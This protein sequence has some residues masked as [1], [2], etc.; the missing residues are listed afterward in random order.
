MHTAP[1]NRP[2]AIEPAPAAVRWGLGAA[3]L[4]SLAAGL[5]CAAPLL[6]LVF[7]ISAAALSGLNGLSWLQAPMAAVAL[8]C[9]GAA[10]FRLYISKRPLCAQQNSRRRLHIYFWATALLALVLL[11]YPFVL[12][13]LLD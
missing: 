3:L 6:Y 10:F 9:L 5:C 2:D 7:G 13:W 4:A 12:P 1:K 11:S 8:L